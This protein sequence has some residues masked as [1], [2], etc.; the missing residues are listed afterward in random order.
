MKNHTRAQWM[1]R[2]SPLLILAAAL[3]VLAAFLVNQAPPA[4]ADHGRDTDVWS[5]TLTAQS[6]QSGP[7]CR[8]PETTASL[9]CSTVSTLTNDEF[10]YLGVN[11]RVDQI[12]YGTELSF[13]FDKDI[14]QSFKDLTLYIG[15]VRTSL[16]D[17]DV[18][19]TILSP[20]TASQASVTAIS[21]GDTVELKLVR[22]IW[23]G[24][25][26][27]SDPDDDLVHIQQGADKGAQYMDIT[28]TKSGTF[29]VRLDQAPT[30]TVT[31]TIGKLSTGFGIDDFDAFTVSPETLTFTTENWQTGQGVTVSAAPGAAVGDS[32]IIA[33]A[34]SI[35]TTDTNDPYRNP[36]RRNGFVVTVK[37]GGL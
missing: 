9:R 24:V 35:N 29:K 17:A 1:L 7:G 13:S 21:A 23:T 22:E 26:L 12:S 28:K 3:V 30:A 8:T 5:A 25:D 18:V 31:I 10:T 6:T 11:Y 14:P 16:A 32:I 33:A 4:S 2:L 36:A 34:V 15:G 27:Y 19:G 20:T 37:T